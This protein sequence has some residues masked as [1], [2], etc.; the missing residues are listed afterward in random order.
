MELRPFVV[1][2]VLSLL[3]SAKLNFNIFFAFSFFKHYATDTFKV[4]FRHTTKACGGSGDVA[5]LF[6]NS[7]QDEGMVNVTSRPLCTG[8]KNSPG[9]H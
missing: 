8:Q 2:F 5:P 4:T 3:C 7:E 1:S 6:L 9:T